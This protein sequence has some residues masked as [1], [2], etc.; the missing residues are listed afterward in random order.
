MFKGLKLN[1]RPQEKCSADRVDK[2]LGELLIEIVS[3]EEIDSPPP[4]LHVYIIICNEIEKLGNILYRKL[5][6]PTTHTN[7]KKKI[8]RKDKSQI[9][10]ISIRHRQRYI[11]RCHQNFCLSPVLPHIS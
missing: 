7:L 6:P 3:L 10:I 8:N 5:T 11:E 2:K 4:F 1:G 9:K